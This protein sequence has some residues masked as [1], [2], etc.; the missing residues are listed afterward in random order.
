MTCTAANTWTWVED[1]V[2]HV[3]A[4]DGNAEKHVVE[5]DGATLD[6]VVN[7]NAVENVVGPDAVDGAAAHFA[8]TPATTTTPN[9]T[10]MGGGVVRKK[11]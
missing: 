2:N 8:A 9:A 3:N 7:Q 1:T 5:K 11:R 4:V 10:K 6:A